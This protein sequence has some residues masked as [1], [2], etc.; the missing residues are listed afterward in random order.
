MK[1]NKKENFVWTGL[2]KDDM[3][4]ISKKKSKKKK[5]RE[6]WSDPYSDFQYIYKKHSRGKRPR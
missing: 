2:T 3:K 6:M 5:T 1:K 4:N